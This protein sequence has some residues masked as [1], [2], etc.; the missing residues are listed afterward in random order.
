VT[1]PIAS[2]VVDRP[3]AVG[4]AKIVT[5]NIIPHASNE[6]DLSADLA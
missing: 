4:A 6:I 1:K 3:G 5:C 2:E